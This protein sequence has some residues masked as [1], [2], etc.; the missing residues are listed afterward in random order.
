LWGAGR[1]QTEVLEQR[2]WSSS[3]RPLELARVENQRQV[4]TADQIRTWCAHPDAQAVV[5]PVLELNEHI[6]VESY[7]APARLREQSHPAR[8]RLRVPVVHP[9]SAEGRCRRHDG[10]KT[11]SPW[12][13]TDRLTNVPGHHT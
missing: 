5:K 1:P 6:Q 4:V 10:L 9:P 11:H 2:W 3:D 12:T 8:P 7:E 13:Y